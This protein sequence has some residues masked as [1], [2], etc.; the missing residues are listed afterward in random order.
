[1]TTLSKTL[2]DLDRTR[3]I[4]GADTDQ[5]FALSNVS[6]ILRATA[7]ADVAPNP[8]PGSTIC[9]RTNLEKKFLPEATEHL[10]RVMG[11]RQMGE[12]T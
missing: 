5:G 8:P 3:R 12:Q 1:M 11:N 4:V 6:E 7:T 10:A 2:G 9:A